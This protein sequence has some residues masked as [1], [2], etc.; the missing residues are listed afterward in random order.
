MSRARFADV[1]VLELGDAEMAED[2]PRAGGDGL[3][4]AVLDRL[5]WRKASIPGTAAGALRQEGEDVLSSRRDLDGRDWWFRARFHWA[6]RTSS[7]AA[8]L[9]AEGLATLC[10]VWLNGTHLYRSENMFVAREHEVGAVLAQ[11]DGD[12]HEL[13][14][15]CASL[16]GHLKARRPRPRWKTRLIA[17]QQLRW[18][19]TTLFGRMA[20]WT[21]PTPAIGPYRPIRL[22][23]RPFSLGPCDLGAE[24]S[25]RDGVVSVRLPV[26]IVP[27][28]ATLIV[29]AGD[30]A[31]EVARAP[32]EIAPG[33]P[34]G[35]DGPDGPDGIGATLHGRAK[36]AD[37]ALWWPHTHGAQPRYQVRLVIEHEGA[38]HAIALGAVGF[39]T[40]GVDR[41]GGA[42]RLVWN[43]APIFCR[44][45]AW[46]PIDA[47]TLGGDEVAYRET[48]ER[49]RSSGMNMVRLSGTTAYEPAR[50][51]DLCDELGILVWQDFMFANMDYPA[52]DPAFVAEVR[53]EAEG[54]ARDLAGRPSLAVLCG[55]SEVAQQA[56][57]LGLPRESW[58]NAIFDRELRAV[59]EA[60]VPSVPYWPSTPCEGP[61]PFTVSEGISHYYGVGAYL[62]PLDDA[63]RAEVRFAAECLAFS[64]I[65]SQALLDGWLADGQ[66]P[67]HHPAW[68]ARVPRD[69]GAGWDFED[70]RDHYL[71][72]LYR[73]DPAALRYGEV[74][75]YLELGRVVTGEVMAAAFAEWRRTGSGCGGA[76]VWTLRDP[77]PGAGWGLLDSTGQPKAAYYFLQRALQPIALLVTNEGSSGVK[78]HAIN[79]TAAPLAATVRVA[80]YRH[81]EVLV[82]SGEQAVELAPR[83][84]TALFAEALLERF[85][86]TTYA[87]RF[88]PPGHDLVVAS[89]RGTDGRRIGEAFFYPLGRPMERR[90]RLELTA[91]ARPVEGGGFVVTLRAQSLAQLLAFDAPGFVPDD[92][93]FDL[94]PGVDR[95]VRLAPRAAPGALRA[96]IQPLNAHA[97]IKV[98]PA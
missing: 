98:V 19:R 10:D 58:S 20:G 72:R 18:V 76:L 61:M 31:G 9:V 73:V 83:S 42:V 97:P 92:D 27:T 39:R 63:R 17:N 26:G 34:A 40:I 80:L 25:G 71:Q 36:I 21:P 93:Y 53:T 66:S 70:V 75:R 48:I 51:H 74:G 5:T 64:N 43:G 37:V 59:G 2:D 32:L 68:K 57:M 55:G 49:V 47:V 69:L 16:T 13:L 33:A 84:V 77:W 35:P 85:S 87:F 81:G 78:L 46:M 38:S 11:N 44:G 94:E 24:V 60:Q 23:A 3:D 91:T 56:A 50:F 89:L 86:D 30:G 8:T 28:A 6:S 82:A 41:Q 4:R 1:P 88:G 12:D 15:R 14:L 95:E 67:A 62:R 45:A 54:V 79:D 7:G 96:T 65:P 29:Y 52:D 22:E 90:P